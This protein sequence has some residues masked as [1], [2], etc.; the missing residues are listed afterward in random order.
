M[1]PNVS[2]SSTSVA[3]PTGENSGIVLTDVRV[4][5]FRSLANIEVG[6]ADLTVLIG[7]NNAGKTS[8]LDA[9]YAAVGAGR[10]ILGQDDIHLAKGEATAPRNRRAVI[11]VKIRP[12]GSDGKIA[13]SFPPGSFWTAL[14]GTGISI[15]EVTSFEFMAFRTS[16]SWNAIK[17]EYVVER[18]CLKEWRPFATWL[19]APLHDKML[20]AAQLEPVA[21]HYIDAKRDLDDDLRRQ[22]SFWRRMTE[23]LG[24]SAGDVTE[25]ET[26]LAG[27][28]QQIVDKSETLKHIK[29]NLTGLQTV[30]S[31]EDI[32]IDISPVATRVR[33]L[34]KA[35][36]VS[37]TSA[38]A[39]SFAL[40]RH[41]MG[42]RSLASLLVFR[43][44][45]SWRSPSATTRGDKVH[46]ILA[47]E[48]PESHLHP[49]AQRSLFSHIKSITGQRI[50]S[51]HSPYFAGQARLEELRLF[52]KR[53][54]VTKV[55][56]L[57]LSTLSKADD[58]RKLQDSVIESRGDILF[59]RAL[60]LFEGQT[61]ELALPIWAQKY[62]GSSIHELGFSFVRVNG[63]DY[64][65][66]IWL[67][68]ALEMPWYVMADGEAR[69]V[70]DLEAALKR[71]GE[72]PIKDC[73]NVIALPNGNSFES[74]IMEDGY[75]AE[76]EKAL[77]EAMGESDYLEG[78]IRS[79][80]GT[81]LPK[82]KGQR[83]YQ[84]SGGR[85]RAALDAMKENKTRVAK[86][87]ARI[88]SELGDTARRFPR[89]I[90]HL[91]E[92]VGTDHGISK[93]TEGTK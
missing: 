14:W 31:L 82:N 36:D 32:G 41:G 57:D 26:V 51:T 39:Q 88:I 66:Y 33:D 30:V 3:A 12:V 17:A 60:V 92:R 50:V 72:A 5:N 9:L 54:G 79:R 93:A 77:D 11:D 40:A 7:A 37:I 35:M 18:R 69:P 1:D 45:A 75:Q 91:L 47:L 62:W 65:P 27:M 86:P 70:A 52:L 2:A 49:Q 83:D 43:A 10:R 42:T 8:F 23:D 16:L 19:D 85:K 84:S 34:S 22:G 56:G 38:G 25:M 74:Q 61:E 59:S 46:S 21:L 48:E 6:L 90:R 13:D 78:Y 29:S 64:Y 73:K 80:H 71:A 28:N 24:L 53:N 81:S 76:V 67:A 15:D 68:R 44:F 58:Q 55:T 87:L 4:S 20:T 63:T 89:H